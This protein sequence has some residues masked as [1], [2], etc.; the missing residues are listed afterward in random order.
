MVLAWRTIG[1]MNVTELPPAAMFTDP[2]HVRVSD[3]GHVEGNVVFACL[4]AFD[5]DRD[6]VA[7][8][9]AQYRLG[10]FGDVQLKRRLDDILQ[11][12]IEPI[13]TRRSALAE[14]P[15]AVLAIVARGSRAAREV[16]RS[17]LDDVR[18]IFDL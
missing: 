10:G 12:L 6:A 8:L 2:A 4:D 7:A 11:A 5:P 18:R 16:V 17:T 14:D 9:K 1:G 3:P 13:R 15:E